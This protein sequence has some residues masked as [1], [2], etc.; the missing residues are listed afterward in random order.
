[1]ANVY[2]V[3]NGNWSD[4][5]LWN[6]LAL[7][8]AADDV[9]ANNFI[10][11]VDIDA[12]VLSIRTTAAA[13]AVA[14]GNF[15]LNHNISLSANVLA[16]GSTC[17]SFLS[18]APNSCTLYGDVTGSGT[19][20]NVNGL[21]NSS[22]GTVNI[23]GN[24]IT[25]NIIS[26][27]G[28]TAVVN[29]STG[30][31]NIRANIIGRGAPALVNNSTGIVSITGNVFGSQTTVSQVGIS[32]NGTCIVYGDVTGGPQVAGGA[33][34]N[35]YGINN[36]AAT[37]VLTVYGNVSGAAFV[38]A[39]G[40]GI[41]NS[42]SGIVS[43][44]G[45]VHGRVAE[46]V[47]N[48]STGTVSITGNVI[49]GT[50]SNI[51]GM[52]N[53]TSSTGTIIVNGN[54]IGGIASGAVGIVNNIGG[55]VI[56]NGNAIANIGSLSYGIAQNGTG[57]VEVNGLAI[58]NDWGLGSSGIGGA[59]P[60]IFGSQTGTTII[61]SLSC[62][63]RGQ[64]PTAGNV[65]IVPQN[66]STITLYTS[67]LS[68]GPSSVLF[69]ALSTNIVPPA[70]SV[71]QGTVYNLGDYRGTCSIPSV[72]SVLQGVSVD[73]SV[74]IAALQ[75]QTIWNYSVLSAT[76]VD[77]LGGRLKEVATVQS[78]GQQLTALS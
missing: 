75:P 72:S 76:D 59:A 49:G 11:W 34:G 65:F 27:G 20:A 41:I 48:N 51:H 18:A 43:I 39:T 54:A 4:T 8:T 10:V 22:T 2:A 38:T 42:S 40:H 45:N 24:V 57:Y 1:M 67:A 35:A 26:Q 74:G 25:A 44:L 36:S 5:T 19:T 37:S 3:K 46:G 29:N 64:W 31:L 33:G 73:N 47:R 6:T 53:S 55:I 14:G 30:T 52:Q 21:L 32:N 77:S 62:G 56:V 9:Y 71:R 16:G 78:V 61:R 17:L 28:A 13:P 15:R 23:F 7:P 70:S 60:G 69:T 63:A 58:G 68:A 50:S 12:Q 66:T